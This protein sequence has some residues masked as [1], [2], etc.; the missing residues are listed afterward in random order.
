MKKLRFALCAAALL[1]IA[2]CQWQEQMAGEDEQWERLKAATYLHFEGR[3][4][5]FV[6]GDLALDHD[7]L[8]ERYE[9]WRDARA[10]AERGELVQQ[11][12]VH[13]VANADDVWSVTD[14][15]NLSYCVSDT[16]GSNKARAVAEM[17]RAARS[18][19]AIAHVDFRYL[20]AHDG[21]CQNGNSAVKFSVRPWG[22]NGTCAFTPSGFGAC[23]PRTLLVNYSF[24]DAPS[25]FP[26]VNSQGWLRHELGHVLGLRHEHVQA[27]APLCAELTPY[28]AITSFDSSSVMNLPYCSSNGVDDFSISDWDALG[29][30]LLYGASFAPHD[31]KFVTGTF[32]GDGK[33]DIAQVFRGWGSIPRCK[34]V[35]HGDWTC[36]NH[37]SAVYD[38]GDPA[39]EVM[40]GNFKLDGKVEIV[41]AH[42]N[43]NTLPRCSKTATTWSCNNMPATI[44]KHPDDTPEQRFLVGNFDGGDLHDVV[45]VYRKWNSIPMC[46]VAASGMS[47]ACS[48]PPATIYD[49]GS[50]E[51]QFLAGHLDY[52]GTASVIQAFRGWN[53]LPVCRLAVNGLSWVCSNPPAT[54]YNS[55]DPEQRFML[56]DFDGDFRAD[57]FQVYR[58]WNHIPVCR[59]IN[60]GTAWSCSNPAATIY[61]SGSTEQQFLV[62][63]FNGDGYSDVAQTYRKWNSI[64]VCLSTGQG[65]WY[66]VNFPADIYDSGSREQRFIA[67]D[68]NG[69]GRTDIMQVYRGWN[70]YPICYG[71]GG[72]QWLC[73]DYPATVFNSGLE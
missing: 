58:G 52:S 3:D 39:Q 41:Q 32:D 64:P 22:G 43:W 37:Q 16:F 24:L 35:L 1:P 44:V 15:L 48:N 13:R 31:Q 9:Q 62:G 42:R 66:C 19:E 23:Q 12:V 2:G 14:K 56:G 4:L 71:R 51:Q 18:W 38:S 70:R 25:S 61:N 50:H 17:Q 46:R 68:M 49:S 33:G 21:N 47:W 65:A 7:Q 60:D 29:I 20:P 69:D 73:E 27:P 28:R 59:S 54:I 6:E 57:V 10:R 11:S 53:S 67:A 72:G 34:N 45:Q 5:Y 40:V 8:R 63:D 55:G 36:S 30:R 26:N